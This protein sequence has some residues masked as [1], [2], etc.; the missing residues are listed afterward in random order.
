VLSRRIWFEVGAL[1]ESNSLIR[2]LA[3]SVLPGDVQ[4]PDLVDPERRVEQ[5]LQL[6]GEVRVADERRPAVDAAVRAS[7]YV[8]EVHAA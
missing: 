1:V 3:S 5:P 7:Q 2:R 4:R 6:V 8:D